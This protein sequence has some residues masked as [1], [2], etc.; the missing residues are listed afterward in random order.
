LSCETG[1]ND[2]SVDLYNAD[3]NSLGGAEL[4]AA[5]EALIR[6][7]D[8]P[9]DRLSEGWILDYKEQWSDEMLKHVAA[10]ANTFGGLLLVGVSER[11]GKPHE[12]IGVQLKSELKTQIASSI[13]ANIS[14]T[15]SFDIGEC[16]HPKDS[17]RRIAIVRIR[18]INRL[19][20]FMKGDKPV[21]V[22]NEDES[23]P[24]NAG[25]L[26]SLIEQRTRQSVQVDSGQILKE[27][28]TN[29][30]VSRAKQAG[31][32]QERRLNR[33]R[34]TT[35][36]TALLYPL[37]RQSFPF[38]DSTEN[39]FD[40]T[41]AL[42][43]PEVA[44]RWNDQSAERSESRGKDWYGVEFWQPNLD[45]EMNWLLSGREAGL[46]TQVNVPVSGFGDSWSIADTVLNIAFLIQS[47]NAIWMAMGFYGT[48]DFACELKVGGLQLYRATQ[49]FHSI[50][51]N[52]ELFIVP[53]IIK[54]GSLKA[55][56]AQAEL[57]T[58]FVSR[59]N[60]SANT[61]AGITNQL[62]RGLG[63]SADIETIR[64]EVAR[65]LTLVKRIY[66]SARRI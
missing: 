65:L 15:P 29:F 26:R 52:T 64:I 49:G 30:Y 7:N 38:D 13:S 4:Y 27:L 41:L 25:Q 11:D 31:T 19:H 44:R 9:A 53:A 36:F 28:S 17:T 40:D 35:S 32:H 8:A 57:Q 60:D 45:F 18:N 2:L 55:S 50:F 59:T 56:V 54:D 3:L 14:P 21:Y 16:I 12:I 43:F 6:L 22:R 39:L 62:L 42:Y 20:Y 37:E 10:F 46:A 63:Y 51:Y 61:V 58:T 34:S 1:V 48:A 24:A 66:P 5:I 23:R 33:T 47:A